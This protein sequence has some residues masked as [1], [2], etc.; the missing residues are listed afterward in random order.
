M[1]GILTQTIG[2]HTS[3]TQKQLNKYVYTNIYPHIRLV[4]DLPC[5][6]ML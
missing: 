3:A 6:N 5:S 2:G 1:W 4:K